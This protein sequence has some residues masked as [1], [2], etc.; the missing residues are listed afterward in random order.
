MIKLLKR[1]YKSVFYFCKR[2]K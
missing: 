1:I 2:R